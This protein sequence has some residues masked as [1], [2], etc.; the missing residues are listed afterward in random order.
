MNTKRSIVKWTDE[1]HATVEDAANVAGLSVPQYT[2]SAA[3][4]M[5]ARG[6]RLWLDMQGVPR[7][8]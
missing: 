3:L 2:K 6:P 5:A 7:T 4:I 8:Q 1:Q